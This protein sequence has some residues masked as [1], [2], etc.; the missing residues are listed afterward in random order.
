MRYLLVCLQVKD[1]VK[2]VVL[3]DELLADEIN[4]IIK[5]SMSN[6]AFSNSIPD[7]LFQVVALNISITDSF[8]LHFS[9]PTNVP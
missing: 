9:C 1:D 2:I 4:K 8:H 3:V 5:N 6:P 7:Q